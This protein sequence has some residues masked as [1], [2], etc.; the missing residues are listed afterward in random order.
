MIKIVFVIIIAV[1]LLLFDYVRKRNHSRNKYRLPDELKSRYKKI[2]VAPA[3]IEILT[4]EYVEEDLESG[5]N[6][7]KAIDALYDPNR[8]YV[9]FK[10]FASVMV[11][12]YSTMGKKYRFRSETIDV[13]P[14][15]IKKK[16]QKTGI[17]DI[18]FEEKNLQLHYFDLSFLAY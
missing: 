9:Q 4:N 12:H 3:N 6:E 15:E 14:D 5:N 11:Y 18:Y 17:I 13:S 16:I 2:S 8:N 7:V 1:L 10:K